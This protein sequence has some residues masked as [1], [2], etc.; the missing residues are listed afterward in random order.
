MNTVLA[1]ASRALNNLPHANEFI[2]KARQDAKYLFDMDSY[3]IS[4]SFLLLADYYYGEGSYEQASY[5]SALARQM[6]ENLKLMDTG[7]GL[8]TLISEVFNTRNEEDRS[9]FLSRATR[10]VPISLVDSVIFTCIRLHAEMR[11]KNPEEVDYNLLTELINSIATRI[12]NEGNTLPPFLLFSLQMM[13]CPAAAVVYWKAG[14]REQ[15]L[16]K[17]EEFTQLTKQPQFK[18]SLL[19]SWAFSI[20]LI[21]EIHCSAGKWDLLQENID[22]LT[23]LANK[24][25]TAKQVLDRVTRMVQSPVSDIF[26][27]Q[28][29]EPYKA[30]I[31]ITKHSL[32]EDT[33]INI[34]VES[35]FEE[36]DPKDPFPWDSAMFLS[37]DF[38]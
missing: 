34:K 21:A 27:S 17:A 11:L 20:E 36:E 7:L 33:P 37:S 2:F 13:I 23:L 3:E 25:N 12:A 14:I 5:C 10:I 18:R 32:F 29:F 19:L 24:Y 26:P 1:Q 8:N 4:A 31:I 9:I 30:E 38:S 28:D 35:K 15:G 16:L 6:C 22:I